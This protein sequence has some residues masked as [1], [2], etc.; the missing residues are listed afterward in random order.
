MGAPSSMPKG[1]RG[2][3]CWQREVAAGIRFCWGPALPRYRL[4]PPADVPAGQRPDQAGLS[5]WGWQRMKR[6]LAAVPG[7]FQMPAASGLL[8]ALR[9]RH[10]QDSRSGPRRPRADA[11][12]ETVPRAPWR[13]PDAARAQPQQPMRA[14]AAACLAVEVEQPRMAWHGQSSVKR[15]VTQICNCPDTVTEFGRA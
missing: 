14:S 4:R 1:S 5:G 3:S 15:S 6:S 10:M 11:G 2:G 7:A 9:P 13:F 8:P 12:R